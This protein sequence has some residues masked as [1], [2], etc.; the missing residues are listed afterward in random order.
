[1]NQ[2]GH[3]EQEL[4]TELRTVVTEQAEV[5]RPRRALPRGRIALATAGG[6]LLAAGLLVGL[7]AMESTPA[8]T[9]YAVVTNP[10]GTVTVT[11]KRIEDADGLERQLTE[12][13]IDAQIDYP[14]EGMMC[15]NTPPRYEPGRPG[16]L[17]AIYDADGSF[18]LVVNPAQLRGKT[19]V[20]EHGAPV[21]N[22]GEHVVFTTARDFGLAA[23]PVAPCELVEA[24]N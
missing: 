21:D 20:L 22:S 13:G 3:F 7:P 12:H 19:L 4:L 8:S 9:A 16:G 14:P 1:M 23:G 6:G 18:S 11:V 5:P 17:T 15:R 24:D 10:D 2:L